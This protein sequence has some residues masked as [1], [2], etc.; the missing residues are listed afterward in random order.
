VRGG[1]VFGL[2]GH[3]RAHL[4]RQRD[5]QR[6]HDDRVWGLR[7]RRHGVQDDVRVEQRL[8]ARQ[9]LLVGLVRGGEGE[10]R[11]VRRGR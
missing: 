1:G 10:R 7:L 3:E 5:V 2:D 4:Q 9:H 8:R 11:G 6:G